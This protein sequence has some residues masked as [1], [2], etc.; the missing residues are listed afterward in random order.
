[1]VATRKPAEVFL[2]GDFIRKELE[3]RHW[4]QKNLASVIGRPVQAINEIIN[5]RKSITA[6]TA[7]QLAAAFGTSAELWLNLESAYQL[8]MADDAD[9]RIAERAEELTRA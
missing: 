5:G 4:T 8:A 6:E 3:A 7:R 9:P 1:M 2:P